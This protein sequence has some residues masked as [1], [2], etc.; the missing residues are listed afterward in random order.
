M[1]EL[2]TKLMLGL[3]T[4]QGV[5]LS[6]LEHPDRLPELAAAAFG[7]CVRVAEAHPQWAAV[8]EGGG[9]GAR[10]FASRGESRPVPQVEGGGGLGATATGGE[11]SAVGCASGG[12][13]GG[14]P[15]GTVEPRVVLSD[16]EGLLFSNEV[17]S[18]VFAE[19]ERRAELILPTK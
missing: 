9:A 1:D 16:P 10:G 3:R 17:I 7:A 4:D 12:G 13:A 15:G 19:M 14:A 2:Q 18:S 5:T 8:Q 11:G 6:E